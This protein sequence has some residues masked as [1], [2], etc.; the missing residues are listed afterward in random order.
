L[1]DHQTDPPAN[2]NV[3]ADPANKPVVE[4]LAKLLADGWAKDVP[5]K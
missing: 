3:A 2:V 1:Y 5:P 4:S